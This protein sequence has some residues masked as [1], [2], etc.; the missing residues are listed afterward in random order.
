VGDGDQPWYVNAVA[1][2]RTRLLPE[3]LF[4]ELQAIEREAGRP[5]RRASGGPRV[6]DLDL[7]LHDEQVLDTP[8]LVLPHPRMHL[9]RFVLE[10]L[11]EI[12][13]GVLHPRTGR[14]VAEMLA[15][16]EDPARV[17]RIGPPAP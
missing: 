13:A 9:R 2:V 3:P 16:L 15:A 6:L 12:A 1:E 14:T 17:E 11:C 7:L 8:D 4:R 5:E 10:P